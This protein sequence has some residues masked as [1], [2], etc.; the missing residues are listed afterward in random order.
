M[1]FIQAGQMLQQ[2]THTNEVMSP[3]T[4]LLLVAMGFLSLAP[5]VLKRKLAKYF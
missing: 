3:K 2:L 5:I 1:F 4:L